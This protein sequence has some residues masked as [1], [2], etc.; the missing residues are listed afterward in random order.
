MLDAVYH[1]L[2]ATHMAGA[3][4]SMDPVMSALEESDINK[5]SI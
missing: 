3:L 4:L 2:H 1:V 5:S